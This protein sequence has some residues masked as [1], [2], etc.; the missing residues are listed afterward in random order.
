METHS[1]LDR[2]PAE[3]AAS[4]TEVRV[5]DVGSAARRQC[6]DDEK[7]RPVADSPEEQWPANTPWPESPWDVRSFR[8]GDRVVIDD[9]GDEG[10]DGE[11]TFVSPAFADKPVGRGAKASLTAA[12]TVKCDAKA[13][14]YPVHRHLDGSTDGPADKEV[15]ARYRV[16]PADLGKAG[17]CRAADHDGGVGT[18]TI[19]AAAG[20]AAVLAAAGAV[21]VVRRARRAR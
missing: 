8:P 5:Q 13:G 7:D 6:H 19:A 17:T 14:L 11:V 16:T 12:T 20:G 3:H 4:W 18:G 15:W 2:H 21:V 9:S 1:Y 10:R